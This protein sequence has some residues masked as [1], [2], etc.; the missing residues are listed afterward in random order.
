M[1]IWRHLLRV[2]EAR[3]PRVSSRRGRCV[4]GAI[5]CASLKLLPECPG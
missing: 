3:G 2:L 4:V 1:I 5:F